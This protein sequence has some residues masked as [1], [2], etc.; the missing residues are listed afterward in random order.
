VTHAVPWGAI[1]AVFL[2]VGNTVVGVD[3][4]RI[5]AALRELGVT[6][7]VRALARAEAAARPE[8]SRRLSLGEGL[9]RDS[10]LLFLEGILRR[11]PDTGREPA[12]VAER[13]APLLR[14]PGHADELWNRPLPGARQALDLLGGL[15]LPV[16][17]ISNSD[18]T[19]AQSLERAGLRD[20]FRAVVDSHFVGAEK[21]DAAIFRAG[22]AEV[23]AAPQRVVHVGDLYAVDVIGAQAAGLHA[24]LLD[25]HR[26]WYGIDCFRARHVGEVAEHLRA[27]RQE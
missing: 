14:R 16:V 17:A 1:E 8:L 9:R 20:A 23:Q 25:P 13:L 26:D 22:L 5:S 11:F 19:A 4:E 27:A 18:G 15:G 24:V 10:F 3:L 12:A 7:G 6:A 21:P 2:D